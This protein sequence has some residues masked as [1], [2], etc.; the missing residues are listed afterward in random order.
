MHGTLMKTTGFTN[1]A[2]G[3]ALAGLLG[4]QASAL[5]A[6]QAP[7]RGALGQAQFSRGGGA[8]QPV[9]KGASFEAGDVIQTANASALDVDFGGA[10]GVVRLT[11]STTVVIERW[12]DTAGVSEL[13]LF[14]RDGEVLGK[15]ARGAAGSRFQLKAGSGLGAV[16]EGQYRVSAKGYVVLL[17]GKA[18]WVHVPAGGEAQYHSLSAPPA[19]YFSPVEGVRP[20][21][22]ELVREVANQSRSKLPKR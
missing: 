14:V 7:V 17:D 4:W 12:T 1:W 2:A 21:P 10:V 22:A 9:G 18:G 20:A 13:N 8:F 3:L 11:E 5:G 15:A 16:V 19:V 6:L